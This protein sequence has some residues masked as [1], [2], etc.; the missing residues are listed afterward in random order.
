MVN[1]SNRC[2]NVL[3]ASRTS[4]CTDYIY[5]CCPRSCINTCCRD[6]CEFINNRT[7]TTLRKICHK[8]FKD[9]NRSQCREKYTVFDGGNSINVRIHR[10]GS[11][12]DGNNKDQ[13]YEKS[14]EDRYR[15][16]SI[17]KDG[18]GQ[19]SRGD[20][21]FVR[22]EGKDEEKFN[23][24]VNVSNREKTMRSKSKEAGEEV[25]DYYDK[26]NQKW[27]SSKR[28]ER[29]S[30]GYDENDP[31]KTLKGREKFFHGIG[32]KGNRNN[33]PDINDR[34]KE[35][36]INKKKEQSSRVNSGNFRDDSE[37]DE[38]Y[39]EKERFGNRDSKKKEKNS[40][41]LKKGEPTYKE[42]ELSPSEMDN[43]K[44]K[45]GKNKYK[46]DKDGADIGSDDAYTKKRTYGKGNTNKYIQDRDGAEIGSDGEYT[47]KRTYGKGNKNKYKKNKDGAYI[48]N[49]DDYTHKRAYGKGNKDGNFENT[50]RNVSKRSS[51]KSKS[52]N[53]NRK[54]SRNVRQDK[55]RKSQ[56][57]DDI[58]KPKGKNYRIVTNLHAKV[59]RGDNIGLNN[60]SNFNQIRKLQGL[61][62]KK[63]ESLQYRYTKPSRADEVKACD[64][65]RALM[66][67]RDLCQLTCPQHSNQFGPHI[68]ISQTCNSSCCAK[69]VI[70]C[71]SES[72]KC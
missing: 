14:S 66:E 3:T 71:F 24:D 61:M 32:K 41:N 57:F 49:D 17:K 42:R 34:T 43:T 7:Y 2:S 69:T 37:S 10:S 5:H 47:Q 11:R 72:C 33:V 1:R 67:Q 30:N 48:D 54:T 13:R 27:K 29:E 19:E 45:K 38:N 26:R 50:T 9:Y 60:E 31:G 68:C 16:H 51:R 59:R 23:F 8:I 64:Y 53:K 58:N 6:Q 18:V 44:T 12:D 62:F 22:K 35:D 65:L 15:L 25:I 28:R 20:K 63:T 56:D 46:K 4:S 39:N 55:Y 36:F 70:S 40:R 52:H 21:L